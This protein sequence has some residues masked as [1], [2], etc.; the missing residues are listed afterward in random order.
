M[1]L[2]KKEKT[3]V[4]KRFTVRLEVDLLDRLS[5]YAEYMASSKDHVISEAI[6]YIIDRDKEYQNSHQIQHQMSHQLSPQ[7]VGGTVG[8]I[9]QQKAA[10]K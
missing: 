8:E 3:V 6:K 10:G 9:P 2:I 7:N 1:S 4:I 5:Q